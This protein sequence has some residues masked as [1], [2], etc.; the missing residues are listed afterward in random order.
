MPFLSAEQ[1]K[2]KYELPK[3]RPHG[4]SIVLVRPKLIALCIKPL[5]RIQGS[6]VFRISIH[7]KEALGPKIPMQMGVTFLETANVQMRVTFLKL[8]MKL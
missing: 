7:L 1:I 3:I 5:K 4:T 8:P 6:K 2:T